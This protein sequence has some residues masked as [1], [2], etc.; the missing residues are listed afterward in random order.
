MR[1]LG[2]PILGKL[3]GVFSLLLLLLLPGSYSYLVAANTAPIDLSSQVV[4]TTAHEQT[5]LDPATGDLT[6]T[7]DVADSQTKCNAS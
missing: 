4:V 1:I 5:L 6:L 3:A 2:K 7:A